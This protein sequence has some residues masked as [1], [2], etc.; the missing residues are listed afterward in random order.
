V[1]ALAITV[2]AAGW[3]VREHRAQVEQQATAGREA[4]AQAEALKVIVE[5]RF[6]P[7]AD[8]ADV[9]QFLRSRTD[10]GDWSGLDEVWLLTGK[11]PSPGWGCGPFSVGLLVRFRDARFV[12]AGVESRGLDCP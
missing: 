12:S 1:I 3:F 7:G 11:E 4:H 9:E 10:Y 2:G 5:Q 6:S 8:R